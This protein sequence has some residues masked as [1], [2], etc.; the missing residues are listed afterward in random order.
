[1]LGEPL[2]PTRT[3]VV[4]LGAVSACTVAV[5]V[6]GFGTSASLPVVLLFASALGASVSAVTHFGLVRPLVT[7]LA[8]SRTAH[9]GTQQRLE[10][11]TT[12]RAFL[13]QLDLAIDRAETEDEAV[14]VIGRALSS[15]LPER[16]NAVLLA[17]PTGSRVTWSIAALEDGLDVPV[18]FDEPHACGALANRVSVRASS[19]D[20]PDACAHLISH[21]W[22]VS[23]LCV[24]ILVGD[25]HLGVA[26]SG[27]PAG[28]LPDD[29]A[30]RL[31][32]VVCRRV[33]HHISAMRSAR[34][35][36][37]A[38]PRDE[39]THLPKSERLSG[40]L[41][42]LRSTDTGFAL[43]LCDLDEFRHYNDCH[44][45]DLGDRALRTFAEVL[46]RTLRPSDIIA[47]YDDDRFVCLF[48]STSAQ[49]AVAAME[50][51]RESL[52]LHLALG[53][54]APFRA[55]VGIVGSEEATTPEAL[56]ELAEMAIDLA[57][58]NGGNRVVVSGV[59]PPSVSS[60]SPAA[61][62]SPTASPFSDNEWS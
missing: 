44:G 50:R 2:N 10:V 42:R 55:S 24:P 37:D 28:D 49:H 58:A 33:G 30:I 56:L 11:A 6:L 46:T 25:R 35:L 21:G 61:S 41:H 5:A 43:A 62:P 4:A 36:H 20:N 48:P 23:S 34:T 39:V 47:R 40:D 14:E 15:F 26:H 52:V 31:I 16:D 29:E 59:T 3:A 8:S 53:E 32:E 19:S 22:E 51:V 38:S 13:E 12:R 54:V 45:A 9:Q 1:M 60:P 17:P 57:K 27:G 7:D 18:I